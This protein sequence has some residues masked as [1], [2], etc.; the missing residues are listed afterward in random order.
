[1]SRTIREA[2]LV[3]ADGTIFEGEDCRLESGH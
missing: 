2:L 1:M 3:L